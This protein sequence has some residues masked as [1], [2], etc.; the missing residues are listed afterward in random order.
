MPN[1]NDMHSRCEV[2]W[3]PH[4]RLFI[5]YAGEFPGLF[6]TD[7]GSGYRARRKINERIR[8][9]LITNDLPASPTEPWAR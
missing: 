1:N 5:A 2:T 8:D 7:A 9:L 3:V 6:H 4:R